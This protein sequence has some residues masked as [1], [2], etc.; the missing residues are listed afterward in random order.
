M[1]RKFS[2]LNFATSAV[3]ALKFMV[4]GLYIRACKTAV[5]AVNQLLGSLCLFQINLGLA[6][7]GIEIVIPLLLLLFLLFF[8]F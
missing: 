3:N 7:L 6:N 8:F 5:L 1:Y 4:R 2:D